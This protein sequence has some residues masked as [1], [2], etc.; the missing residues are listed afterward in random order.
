MSEAGCNK[1]LVKQI[2]KLSFNKCE[3]NEC[4]LGQGGFGDV[5]RGQFESKAN[6]A[7]KRILI[8]RAEVKDDILLNADNHQ[9]ILRYYTTETDEDL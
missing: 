2:G 7:V 1:K 6:V 8:T 5:Y 3:C 9:N 4:Y